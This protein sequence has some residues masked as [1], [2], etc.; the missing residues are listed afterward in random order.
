MKS[1]KIY[2]NNLRVNATVFKNLNLN[3][4][5]KNLHFQKFI[6]RK[7][8]LLLT[9]KCACSSVKIIIRHARLDVK[10]QKH[11]TIKK[12]IWKICENQEF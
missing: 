9:S 1:F 8:N 12:K 2:R 10:C 4:R 6:K 5:D 11:K 3:L 7:I